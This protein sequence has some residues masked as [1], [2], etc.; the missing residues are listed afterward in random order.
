VASR[1]EVCGLLSRTLRCPPKLRLVHLAQSCRLVGTRPLESGVALAQPSRATSQHHKPERPAHAGSE[2][3][4]QGR[5]PCHTPGRHPARMRQTDQGIVGQV[6]YASAR[7][8]YAEHIRPLLG[9]SQSD[10]RYAYWGPWQVPSDTAD[11]VIQTT[12]WRSCRVF[13]YMGSM[14]TTPAVCQTPGWNIRRRVRFSE[15]ELLVGPHS[16]P[17]R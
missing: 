5:N 6:A 7:R 10:S 11:A 17:Y 12:V 2:Q 1:P 15:H 8:R 3:R 16:G 9:H 14:T 4:V 13:F